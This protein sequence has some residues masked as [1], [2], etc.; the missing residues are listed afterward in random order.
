MACPLSRQ[1]RV[2]PPS[3]TKNIANISVRDMTPR[4]SAWFPSSMKSFGAGVAVQARRNGVRCTPSISALRV[5][6]V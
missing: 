4:N 2:D 5:D 6:D 3:W 1:S